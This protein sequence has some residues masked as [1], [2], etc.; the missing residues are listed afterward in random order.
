MGGPIGDGGPSRSQASIACT[1]ARSV[2]SC[3]DTSSSRRTCPPSGGSP[4]LTCS[5]ER[6]RSLTDGA[7]V[8]ALAL[9][10][11]GFEHQW[12]WD[13]PSP[14]PASPRRGVDWLHRVEPLHRHTS[15]LRA[16]RGRTPPSPARSP[17][18]FSSRPEP[19]LRLDDP[20]RH[21]RGRQG[22]QHRRRPRGRATKRPTAARR[23][24]PSQR[25]RRVPN[26][27]R[28]R[29]RPLSSRWIRQAPR[30]PAPEPSPPEQRPGAPSTEDHPWFPYRPAVARRRSSPR[31]TSQPLESLRWDANPA[32]DGQRTGRGA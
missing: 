20:I 16:R 22:L 23:T 17:R 15:V 5:M 1:L 2:T 6:V 4:G 26:G 31:S 29:F 3:H 9:F 13:R 18:C 30:R 32:R 12:R 27:R 8:E 24:R 21:R 7:P 14:M 11:P 19:A 25:A 10:L 28:A